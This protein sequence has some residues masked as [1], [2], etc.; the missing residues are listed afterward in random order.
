MSHASTDWREKTKNEIVMGEPKESQS[1]ICF[2]DNSLH[3]IVFHFHGWFTVEPIVFTPKIRGPL[4][5][6]SCDQFPRRPSNFRSFFA[7]G[8]SKCQLGSDSLMCI[9]IIIYITWPNLWKPPE[10]LLLESLSVSNHHLFRAKKSY[11]KLSWSKLYPILINCIWHI[12]GQTPH[13]R[14]RNTN[15]GLSEKWN[16]PNGPSVSHW[17]IHV[18][19]FGDIDTRFLDEPGKQCLATIIS[20]VHPTQFYYILLNIFISH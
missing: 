7:M 11:Q 6:K 15:M 20:Q 19:D 4:M 18:G 17:N 2:G 14:I 5:G 13:N 1:I 3:W 8:L 10:E 9:Y 16:P 12:M